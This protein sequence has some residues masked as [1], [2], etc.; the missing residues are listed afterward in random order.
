M[1]ETKQRT[2]T[3]NQLEAMSYEDLSDKDLLLVYDVDQRNNSSSEK[4]K[5]KKFSIKAFKDGLSHGHRITEG[6]EYQF[7]P[8]SSGNTLKIKEVGAMSNYA[9]DTH[10]GIISA[11]TYRQIQAIGDLADNDTQYKHTYKDEHNLD[12]E[13]WVPVK[14]IEKKENSIITLE[15]DNEENG[16]LT[17]GSSIYEDNKQPAFTSISTKDS[18]NREINVTADSPTSELK[19]KSEGAIGIK[20]NADS[21][22]N[23]IVFYLQAGEAGADV[24][25]EKE[26]YTGENALI[27]RLAVLTEGSGI[28]FEAT[29]QNLTI[30]ALD[31]SI[32]IITCNS[33]RNDLSKAITVDL[34]KQKIVP[35]HFVNGLPEFLNP[36]STEQLSFAINGDS[37]HPVPIYH[38]YDQHESRTRLDGN[39]ENLI[40]YYGLFLYDQGVFY[41]IGSD[42]CGGGGNNSSSSDSTPAQIT[43]SIGDINESSKV[44]DEHSAG[45]DNL[46]YKTLNIDGATYTALYDIH[47]DEYN[48]VAGLDEQGKIAN[49]KLHL[50]DENPTNITIDKTYI[51]KDIAEKNEA[52]IVSYNPSVEIALPDDALGF[53][54]SATGGPGGTSGLVGSLITATC[55]SSS[56]S[57]NKEITIGSG[58]AIVDN[59]FLLVKFTQNFT[60]QQANLVVKRYNSNNNTVEN[61]INGSIY[62]LGEKTFP[63][64]LISQADWVLFLVTVD[65]S[66]H[67][68]FEVI[69]ID[70]AAQGSIKEIYTQPQDIYEVENSEQ[71][72]E[73]EN[74]YSLLQLRSGKTFQLPRNLFVDNNQGGY[75]INENFV[76]ENLML[77]AYDSNNDM[78]SEPYAIDTIVAGNGIDFEIDSDSITINSVITLPDD[79]DLE[80]E[81]NESKSHCVLTANGEFENIFTEFFVGRDGLTNTQALMTIANYLF[82]NNM[83]IETADSTPIWEYYGA[84]QEDWTLIDT[85]TKTV[86][87]NEITLY[88][89]LRTGN[90]GS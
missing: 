67:Y 43:V 33:S 19:I 70:E 89:Y 64:S 41:L 78:S 53:D 50:F 49:E 7:S 77:K 8:G 16:K 21:S 32:D 69:A 25:V 79:A 4:G 47:K 14:K 27:Q 63:S 85:T 71:I 46:S 13:K 36:T 12:V 88:K 56:D 17:I 3:I 38:G 9:S 10:D 11:D 75:R 51:P 2:V 74:P 30:N 23:E 15:Y 82:K 72:D 52:Y 26:G 1:A 86:N 6:L 61:Y 84:G 29:G 54:I 65:G 87:G 73:D 80:L 83:V 68:R 48:G 24:K 59:S 57:V 60:T 62:Y 76:P 31:K 40:R 37:A 18:T 20:Q 58:S 44:V 45:Q 42:C 28:K 90:T 5:A 66:N 22:S 81:E 55:I 35:V 39:I 34:N